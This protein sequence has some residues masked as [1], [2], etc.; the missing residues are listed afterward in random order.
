VIDA[1]EWESL[2]LIGF[3]RHRDLRLA[4][5]PGLATWVAANEVGKSTSVLGLVA[6]VWGVATD[7]VGGSRYSWERFKPVAG[8]AGRGIVRFRRGREHFTITRTFETN[9]IRVERR[10]GDAKEVLIEGF[11]EPTARSPGAYGAWLRATMGID[12]ATQALATFVVT[13]D[14]LAGP[15]HRLGQRVQALLVGAGGRTAAGAVQALEQRI[16]RL[17]RHVVGVIPDVSRDGVEDRPLDLLRARVE[18]LTAL[19]AIH[20]SKLEVL[21]RTRLEVAN[22]RFVAREARADARRR[23]TTIV[24]QGT[25]SAL[26]ADA[27]AAQRQ[28]DALAHDLGEAR[29]TAFEFERAERRAQER[30]PHLAGLDPRTTDERLVAWGNAQVAAAAQ[31]KRLEATRRELALA[32]ADAEA[33]PPPLAPADERQPAWFR[34][35]DAA[36]PAGVVLSAVAVWS[37]AEAAARRWREWMSIVARERAR[38]AASDTEIAALAL[39]EGLSEQDLVDLRYHRAELVS[40]SN[41]LSDAEATWRSWRD[42]LDEL[43]VR[44]EPV[45]DLP[46]EAVEDLATLARAAELPDAWAPWVPP[47]ALA[48]GIG[49]GAWAYAVGAA[50]PFLGTIGTPALLGAIGAGAWLALW[51]RRSPLVRARANLQRR[52][53]PDT[54]LIGSD[55]DLVQIATLRRAFEAR[56]V[57]IDEIARAE[58]DAAER[59]AEIRAGA[60]A[61][62]DRWGPWRDALVSAGFGEEVDLGAVGSRF[63]RLRAEREESEAEIARALRRLGIDDPRAADPDAPAAEAGADAATLLAWGVAQGVLAADATFEALASY[64]EL[65]DDDDW[66]R[67]LEQAER[68]DVDGETRR[69][70]IA[71]QERLMAQRQARVVEQV[72]Q[73]EREERLTAEADA[74]ARAQRNEALAG[75]RDPSGLDDANAVRAAWRERVAAFA[76]VDATSRRLATLLSRYQ[77][78]SFPELEAAYERAVGVARDALERWRAVVAEHPSLPAADLNVALAILGRETPVDDRSVAAHDPATRFGENALAA[79]AAERHADEAEV[80]AT[81]IERRLAELETEVQ[82]ESLGALRELPRLR[83]ELAFADAEF[84]AS[85]LAYDALRAAAAAYA[86]RHVE[87]IERSASG[88]LATFSPRSGRSV[89]F[90]GDLEAEVVEESGQVL[91]PEQ[92]SQGARDQLALAL[93]LAVIDLM[94]DDVRLPIVLD[95]PFVSWDLPRTEAARASLQAIAARGRQ[96]WLLS[97][98]PEFESWGRPVS[99]NGV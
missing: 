83:E 75:A 86:E 45:A 12:D 15:P 81:G 48:I 16:R 46:P 4:F 58:R 91:R 66:T 53:G 72:R 65:L 6:T 94:A 59:L 27:V 82:A 19:E 44:F 73:V 11:H 89:R 35:F 5:E 22:A 43:R 20:E 68:V 30:H 3:G 54:I 36:T 78:G 34:H 41:R 64:A 76:E 95:D 18:E 51:P 33:P 93:R 38:L 42:R 57:E 47:S 52:T 29:A 40:W 56:S 28:A 10:S 96:V 79:I 97:H 67:W 74:F 37:E 55:E 71:A 26:R 80:L 85:R 49:F 92:L 99:V 60:E 7:A 24:A 69:E 50:L 9:A 70:A 90:R 25:W 39:L 61:F 14:D 13:Q 88:Y 17:T 23:R 77:V 84:Q 63:D 32:R 31:T 8:E 62:G 1:V 2:R 87:A 98:R 21:T